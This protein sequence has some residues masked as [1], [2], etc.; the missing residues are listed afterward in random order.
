MNDHVHLEAKPINTSNHSSTINT[1]CP[2]SHEE[3]GITVHGKLKLCTDADLD[4]A[5]LKRFRCIRRQAQVDAGTNLDLDVVQVPLFVEQYLVLD[6]T[7]YTTAS[8]CDTDISQDVMLAKLIQGEISPHQSIIRAYS[9][10][11][12]YTRF[13]NSARKKQR[14]RVDRVIDKESELLD[15]CILNWDT[16]FCVQSVD[17]DKVLSS[18]YIRAPSCVTKANWID[19]LKSI[20]IHVQSKTLCD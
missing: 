5:R 18:W 17:G 10:F 9:S 15:S 4:Y 8:I 20:N 7:A 13:C 16:D 14:L 12:D 3:I 6:M 1:S 2:Q 11:Q 19:L